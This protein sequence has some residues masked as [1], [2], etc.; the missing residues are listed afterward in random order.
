MDVDLT[1]LCS[2]EHTCVGCKTSEPCCCS[3]YEVCVTA[4]EM[5]RIIEVLP[6]AAKLCRHL[7]TGDGY[8]NVF[9]KVDA[10]L[11]A[12]DTTDEGRCL[13][14]YESRRRLRCA[15]HTVA[16]ENGL[17]ITAVKPKSCLL[18][19]MTFSEGAEAL[20]LTDDALDFSCNAAK[21]KGP[22]SISPAFLE[23]IELVYGDGSGRLV[24][25]AV[26]KGAARLRLDG[27]RSA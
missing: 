15:L 19:P 3:A 20:S 4:A 1:S 14:L 25:Q 11:Y 27:R 2:V 22:A 17:P 12:I 18:W 13:F 9:E 26:K 16:V 23:A 5:G 6:A 24:Q 21:R 8:D 7:A 10:G